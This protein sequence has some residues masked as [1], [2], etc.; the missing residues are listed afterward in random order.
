MM[1]LI[2]AILIRISVSIPLVPPLISVS[3]NDYPSK[4]ENHIPSMRKFYL[5]REGRNMGNSTRDFV[6]DIPVLRTKN[7]KEGA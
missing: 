6:L 3:R 1:L 2:K 7:K 5:I 4:L